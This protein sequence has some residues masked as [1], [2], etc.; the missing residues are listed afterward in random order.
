MHVC[1][2]VRAC[3]FSLSPYFL[4]SEVVNVQV[5]ISGEHAVLFKNLNPHFIAIAT[6]T[7]GGEKCH[8]DRHNNSIILTDTTFFNVYTHILF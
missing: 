5:K 8:F 1:V 7:E 4:S 3:V 2:C 6:E